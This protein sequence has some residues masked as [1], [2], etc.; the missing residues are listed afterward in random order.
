MYKIKIKEPVY[1]YIVSA[2]KKNNDIILHSLSKFQQS[3]YV[4]FTHKFYYKRPD[5]KGNVNFRFVYHDVEI[6]SILCRAILSEKY[7][8]TN[9]IDNEINLLNIKIEAWI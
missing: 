4:Q 5:T 9:F 2:C 8:V 1:D 6:L 7:D 3:V